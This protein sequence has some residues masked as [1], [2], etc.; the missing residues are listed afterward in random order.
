MANLRNK[1]EEATVKKSHP[2]LKNDHQRDQFDELAERLGYTNGNKESKLPQKFKKIKK[3]LKQ[4]F[5]KFDFFC[6]IF[7]FFSSGVL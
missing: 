5:E 2:R 4:F 1:G 6:Q 7:D 3:K